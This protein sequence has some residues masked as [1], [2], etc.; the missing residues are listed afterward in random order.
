VRAIAPARR[1][2]DDLAHG[3]E[4]AQTVTIIW[5]TIGIA[6]LLIWGITVADLIK[7]R[8][9]TGQTVAWLLIVVIVPFL[10][11]ILY[12]AMRKPGGDEAALTEA[13]QRSRREQAARR[14]F[15]ST[16]PGP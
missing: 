13:A 1:P 11:A 9:S 14:P 12:W 10:G 3:V 6:L 4:P 8:L 5:F 2:L 7:R 15:D 16:R